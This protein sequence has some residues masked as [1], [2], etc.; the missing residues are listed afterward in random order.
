MRP[1]PL[2]WEGSHLRSLKGPRF[3][4]K[5]GQFPL[6]FRKPVY[7]FKNAIISV[8]LDLRVKRNQRA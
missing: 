5:A 3:Y 6:S 7:K 1:Y 8:I 2:D 4:R